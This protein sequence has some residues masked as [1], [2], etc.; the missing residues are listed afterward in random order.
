MLKRGTTTKKEKKKLDK[1]EDFR[2]NEF[3]KLLTKARRGE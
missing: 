1:L 3:D 2:A